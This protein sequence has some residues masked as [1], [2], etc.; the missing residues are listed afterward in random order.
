MTTIKLKLEN[1]IDIDL[2]YN[3]ITI[4]QL[5]DSI[6]IDLTNIDKSKISNFLKNENIELIAPC[7]CCDLR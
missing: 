1:E 3:N 5:L 7:H 4:N 2:Y 6:I